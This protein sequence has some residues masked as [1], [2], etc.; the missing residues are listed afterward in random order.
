MDNQNIDPNQTN[1]VPVALPEQP[2]PIQP[3]NVVPKKPNVKVGL[4]WFLSPFIAI[5]GLIILTI[6]MH[7]IK[8]PSGLTSGIAALGGI[9]VIALFPIGIIRGIAKF[10]GK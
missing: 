4:F 3:Q 10:S 6:L 8:A 9:C 7:V 1:Q 2:A 5:I